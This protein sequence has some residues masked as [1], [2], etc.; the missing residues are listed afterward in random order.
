MIPSPG[1]AAAQQL[2]SDAFRVCAKQISSEIQFNVKPNLITV[3]KLFIAWLKELG[4]RR[5]H[6]VTWLFKPHDECESPQ[7]LSLCNFQILALH[8]TA[9]LV[10]VLYELYLGPQ[11]LVYGI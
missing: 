2:V 7:L 6:H 10:F 8:D 3:L 5:F 11:M 9:V 1:A 4:G